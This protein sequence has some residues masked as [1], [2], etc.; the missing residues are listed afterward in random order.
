MKSE[1]PRS[2]SHR[3]AM[4]FSCVFLH[5]SLGSCLS[6]A[7]PRSDDDSPSHRIRAR[8]GNVS[9]LLFSSRTF[10]HTPL[11]SL[12]SP[13]TFVCGHFI[14]FPLITPTWGWLFFCFLSE[15]GLIQ[16][17]W[18]GMSLFL[19]SI[20][21]LFPELFTVFKFA[22][23]HISP[24]VKYVCSWDRSGTY[25][26]PCSPTSWCPIGSSKAISTNFKGETPFPH[27][28]Y[29][30]RGKDPGNRK[31]WVRKEGSSWTCLWESEH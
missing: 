14:T 13:N 27:I 3:W 26:I 24:L 29:R 22:N 11:M 19:L 9:Q 2:L 16:K 1:W 18:K 6:P 4:G 28:R 30:V 23:G 8:V 17:A 20:R 25:R 31:L 15:L 5:P 21:H 12:N 7:A 10:P